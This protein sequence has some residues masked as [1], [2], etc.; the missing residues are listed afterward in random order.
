MKLKKKNYSKQSHVK[1]KSSNI[2]KHGNNISGTEHNNK[3]MLNNIHASN[4]NKSNERRK[5]K[6]RYLLHERALL[7]ERIF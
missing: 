6:K 1:E 7:V 2:F 3:N 4:K 5:E